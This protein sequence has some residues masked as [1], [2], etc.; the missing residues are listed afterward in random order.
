[1]PRR[2]RRRNPESKS[3]AMARIRALSRRA[4][5]ARLAG[6]MQEA[7]A[8]DRQIDALASSAESKGWADDVVEAE[9]DGRMSAGR[10]TSRRNPR[11]RARRRNPS[12]GLLPAIGG[13]IGVPI[14]THLLAGLSARVVPP[15]NGAA[16]VNGRAQ[17]ADVGAAILAWAG[18]DRIKDPGWHSFATG[19]MWGSIVSAVLRPVVVAVLAARGEL[20]G[21]S[22]VVDR[23]LPAPGPAPEEERERMLSEESQADYAPVDYTPAPSPAA[24][25][26]PLPSP[27]PPMPT[28]DDAFD[29]AGLA[30]DIFDAI[31]GVGLF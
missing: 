7:T 19:G 18:R 12:G 8:L 30:A 28:E 17:I 25:F 27:M 15:S 10:R 20:A 5:A 3:A 13:F 14:A 22:P 4:A 6:R 1:M 29:G 24:D 16:G 23:Q 26:S 2:R 11:R 21:P 31:P 9:E